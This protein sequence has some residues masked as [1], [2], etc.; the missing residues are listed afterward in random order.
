LVT[1]DGRRVIGRGFHTGPLAGP[2]AGAATQK[3]LELKVCELLRIKDGQIAESRVYFDAAT[4]MRQ[5]GL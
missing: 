3:K 1:V 5:L 4:M 2:Q